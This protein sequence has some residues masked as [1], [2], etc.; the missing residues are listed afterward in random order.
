MGAIGPT[1]QPVRKSDGVTAS[2]RYLSRLGERSF[3]SLWTYP[4]VYRDQGKTGGGDGKEVCDLLVVFGDHV[5]IFSDKATAYPDTGH[6]GRDWCRWFRKSVKKSAEQVWGAERWIRTYPTRLFLDRAC[7]QPFPIDLPTT[8]AA[9]F[10]RVVVAR[11]ASARCR[12]ALGGSGSLML[13]PFVVGPAH[14]TDEGSVKMFTVGDLDPSKGFV[15]VLDDTSLGI[16]MRELDTTSDFVDYLT[17]KE[18][19]VR[20]GR[21]GGATG[22]EELLAFYLRNLNDRDENDFIVPPGY[23]GVWLQEGLWQEYVTGP[24]RIARVEADEVSYVWDR[25]IEKFNRHTLGGTSYDPAASATVSEREQAVR[26]MAAEPRTSRRLLGK[27]L[28]Q[29]LRLSKPGLRNTRVMMPVRPGGP[30]YVFLALSQPPFATSYDEY[31]KVRRTLLEGL[32]LVTK[33]VRPE[34]TGIVGFATEAGLGGERSE[35][36]MYYDARQWC[37]EHRSE[38]ERFQRELGLLTQC[39]PPSRTTEY[40]FPVAPVLPRPQCEASPKA[41]RSRRNSPCPC[42]NGKK[43]KRCCGRPRTGSRRR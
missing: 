2:E 34:V 4:G 25:V 3:L 37:E 15:H 30:Y 31:R 21:F 28:L 22:E 10:H 19:F 24:L 20:G 18:A 23:N 36:V 42:G 12:A 7:A 39:G 11:T 41:G 6:P 32:C 35:D 29:F 16:L 40:Q 43:W 8:A 1:N 38:A 26:L 13:D 5:I 27:S 14:F 9:K 33:L 17:K